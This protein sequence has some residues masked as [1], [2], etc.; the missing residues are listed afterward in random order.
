[1]ENNRLINKKESSG[2]RKLYKRMSMKTLK[3]KTN[4]R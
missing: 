2:K 3:I 4:Q 1:M